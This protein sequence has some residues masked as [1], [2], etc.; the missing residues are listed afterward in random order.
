MKKIVCVIIAPDL[1]KISSEGGLDATL[2][3]ILGEELG[4]SVRYCH[5]GIWHS[6]AAEVADYGTGI[7][8]KKYVVKL[9]SLVY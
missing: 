8:I 2:S 1:E 6:T 9:V 7:F 5:A 4:L 3:N